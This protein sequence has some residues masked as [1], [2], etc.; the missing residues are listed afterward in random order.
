MPPCRFAYARVTHHQ[1]ASVWGG[2][3]SRVSTAAV[4]R[5]ARASG[6]G[7]APRDGENCACYG[8]VVSCVSLLLLCV[9]VSVVGV[10]RAFAAQGIDALPMIAYEPV[11]VAKKDSVDGARTMCGVSHRE[12]EDEKIEERDRDSQGQL[13]TCW[14]PV[15]SLSTICNSHVALHHSFSA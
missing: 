3:S 10:V 15:A 11:G 5:K 8:I 7:A 2:G 13:Q 6:A 14:I 1:E 9:F 12:E 4:V